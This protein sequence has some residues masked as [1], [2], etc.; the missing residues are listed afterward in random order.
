L[1]WL[2]F[3]RLQSS[4]RWSPGWVASRFPPLILKRAP[5]GDNRDDYTVLENGVVWAGYSW[6]RRLRR[7]ARH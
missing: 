5:I 4:L 1:S 3:L 2:A 7:R 6:C